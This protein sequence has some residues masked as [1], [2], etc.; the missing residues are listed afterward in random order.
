MSGQIYSIIN[1]TGSYIPQKIVH[2]EDF[3]SNTFYDKSGSIIQSD[4]HEII[5][6]F[7]QITAISERRYIDDNLVTSDIAS[8]AAE[9]A[10]KSS[11]TDPESL[12]Y[13]IAAHNFGDVRSNNRRTD[14][15]PSIASR[16]KAKLNIKN[17]STVA[18]DVIFGCPGWLQGVIQA[19]Y[20][21]KSGDAKKVMVIGAECLSRVSD[22]CDRDSMLYS[23]GAGAVIFEAKESQEP[24]GILSHAA[25]TDAVE[26]VKL[27]EMDKSYNP[28]ENDKELFLKMNGRKLYEY[29]LN[30]VP[31]LVKS[32][33]ER[34]KLSLQKINK[35]LIHQANGKMDDAIMQRLLK[36]CNL[37]KCITNLAK[38]MPMTIKEFGNNSVAT[39]PIML[40]LI[41]KNKLNGHEILPGDNI[42]FA[43]VGAGMSINAL[44]YKAV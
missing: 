31:Q 16:V 37:D 28:D 14:I 6:K 27:L 38:L 36:L 34:A 35:V 8:I 18:Y 9:D 30:Y 17:P 26:Y 44:T 19:D 1:G 33:I 7:E 10:I 25:R 41:L 21:I 4:T 23:D 43:S 12:D 3:L 40:D 39:L 42:V 2:N 15:V 24:I 5:K 20:F 11:N 32:C 22:M 29:A 13:I